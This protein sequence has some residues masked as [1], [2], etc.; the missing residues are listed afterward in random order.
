MTAPPPGWPGQQPTSPYPYGQP[1]PPPPAV[2]YPGYPGYPP[3]GYPPPGYGYPPPGYPPPGYPAWKPGVIPLRP[4]TLTDIFN[5]SVAY[6]RA[7]PK[8]TL[9]LT[10]VIIL[11]TTVIGFVVTLLMSSTD[12]TLQAVAGAATA[13]LAS[14]VATVVLSGMLAVIVARSVLGSPITA[15]QA[16]QRVRPLMPAL[17]G[18]TL[19]EIVAAAV[20][21]AAIVLA[22]IGITHAG[23]GVIATLIGIPLVLLGIAALAYLRTALSLA[24]VA[25]V[26]ERK[27][28]PDSIRRSLA[29]VRGRFWRI[30]G[31]LLLAGVVAG[32]VAGAISVPFGIAGNVI[33]LGAGHQTQTIGG[34]MVATIGQAIGQIII[35]PFLAGV[36]TLLY[37]DARIRSEAFDFTLMAPGSADADSLWLGR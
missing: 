31:I 13:G 22:I 23:G 30:L 27:N 18:L 33:T 36:T 10:T 37:V 4:L 3:P 2:S 24:P 14:L 32:F 1:Y 19:L 29:L 17:I 12:G 7:N 34:T 28:I 25:I 11:I 9:G 15:A 8:P 20:V 21:V 26:L 6:V 35:T 16:W 5:G